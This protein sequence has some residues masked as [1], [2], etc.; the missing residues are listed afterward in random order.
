MEGIKRVHLI[1]SGRVQ[2]VFFRAWIQG[3][4]AELG[5]TGWVKNTPEG[6]VE[7]IFEGSEEKINEM[8]QKCYEGPRL[9]QIK[10]IEV[11]WEGATG[12]FGNFRMIK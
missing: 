10:E 9:A 11:K 12:E 3:K 1:I 7:A 8:L 5:L 6:K 4:A 2:G